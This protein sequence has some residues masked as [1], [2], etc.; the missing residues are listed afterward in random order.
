MYINRI[1]L[2]DVRNFDNLD[3]KLRNNWTEEPL[4]SILLTGPNGSGKTTLLRVIAALWENFSGWLRLRKPL[5]NELQAQRV[6][7][8]QVGLAAIEIHGLRDFPIWL[9]AVSSTEYLDEL[10][11]IASDDKA[12]FIGQIKRGVHGRPHLE[13]PKD[14]NWFD[15][16]DEQKNRLQ[17]G[18][19][20]APSLPNLIFLEAGTRSIITP[21]KRNTA[22]VYSETLY[23]WFVTYEARDRWD[24]HIET[25]LQNLKLRSSQQ[26]RQTLE[27]INQFFGDDKRITDFDNN[28]RLRVEIF[29]GRKIRT[30]HYIDELSNGE[31]QC[32]LLMFM[33]SRWLMPGGI[34]LIDEPDLHLHVSLQRQFIHELEKV[35]ESRQG[36]LIVASHSPTMWEEYNERQ[37]IELG[38][39]QHE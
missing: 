13:Y 1:I 37:R 2:R 33:V 31:Q 34:V 18:V 11:R 30:W 4:R 15:K 16:L 14:A 39:L 12:Q 8:T 21:S 17:V 6:L 36:Q 29:E 22:E 23:Q 35:V 32:L 24:K 28:L 10:Q 19:D 5:N 3:L 38:Q 25:M 27:L 9:F 20:N 26:F 7:L